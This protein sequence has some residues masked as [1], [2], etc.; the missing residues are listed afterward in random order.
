ME[1]KMMERC[2]RMQKTM[3]AQITKSIWT[4]MGINCTEERQKR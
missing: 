2:D 1:W 3:D 4:I